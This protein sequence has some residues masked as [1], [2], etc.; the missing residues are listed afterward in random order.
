MK[1]EKSYLIKSNIDLAFNFL[2]LASEPVDKYDIEEFIVFQ[3]TEDPI[4]YQKVNQK[5]NQKENQKYF[6]KKKE[7]T[8]K[9][10]ESV[11]KY[12]DEN[13]FGCA[14]DVKKIRYI[15]KIKGSI[16][17]LDVYQGAIEGLILLKTDKD[18]ESLTEELREI[19]IRDVTNEEIYKR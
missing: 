17:L 19:V 4:P 1:S 9:E 18:I 13:M 6:R 10:F 16:Y 2:F 11:V 5:V 12:C 14:G 7:I 3:D 8:K 15:A